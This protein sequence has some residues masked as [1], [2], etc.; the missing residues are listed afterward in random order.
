MST[1]SRRRMVTV[2]C[3]GSPRN[4]LS[5]GQRVTSIPLSIKRRSNRKLLIPPSMS[6]SDDDLGGFDEPMIRMLGK[7]F[8]WKKLIDDGRYATIADLSYALKVDQGWV[9]EVI[10]L[11]LLAPD[12]VT[13]LLAGQQPRHLNLHA[14]RGRVASIPRDWSEQRRILGFPEA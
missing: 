5:N 1:H 6:P 12:I 9:A 3:D 10:R 4:Y 11:T 2:D 8:L 7:A 14:L 13:A